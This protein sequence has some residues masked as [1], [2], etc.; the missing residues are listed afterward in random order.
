MSSS[1]CCFLTCLQISQEASQVV[2]YSHLLKNFPQFVVIHT[3]IR[4]WHSQQSWS[5]CFSGTLLLFRWSNG[6]WQFDSGLVSNY[7]WPISN[8]IL[9]SGSPLW[10]RPPL[11]PPPSSCSYFLWP[12]KFHA[13]SH[14]VPTLA[15][16][17]PTL[18]TYTLPSS[19]FQ[20]IIVLWVFLVNP[21]TCPN[22]PAPTRGPMNHWG[23]VGWFDNSSGFWAGTHWL[24]GG[25]FIPSHT[26]QHHMPGIT[27][28]DIPAT[29]E[30]FLCDYSYP[31]D[32]PLLKCR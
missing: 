9:C 4:L 11:P 17:H 27:G 31:Q 10:R 22:R 6:C 24:V 32:V 20:V 3:V 13:G 18:C 16:S 26:R 25:P 5:K 7:Y 19:V 8:E 21:D 30:A 12:S 2:W 28:F 29:R 14:P 23:P 1:I 15:P